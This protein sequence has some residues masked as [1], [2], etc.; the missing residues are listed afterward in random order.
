MITISAIA[1]GAFVTLMAALF[2]SSMTFTVV[3]LLISD[4]YYQDSEVE[5]WCMLLLSLAMS[6][7]LWWG[8]IYLLSKTPG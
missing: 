6:V 5:D 7:F 2:F 4:G 8:F 1:I 3:Y